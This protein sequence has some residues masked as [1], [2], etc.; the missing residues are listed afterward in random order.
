MLDVNMLIKKIDQLP[1]IPAVIKRLVDLTADPDA[2]I[3]DILELIERDQSLTASIIK[4]C[5]SSYYG[6]SKKVSSI[7]EAVV[8]VGFNTISNM[9]IT[10]GPSIY[11][12]KKVLVYDGEDVD[13]WRHS[14]LAGSCCEQLAFFARQEMI[15]V[16]YT[17][18][19]LHDIGKLVLAECDR[20]LLQK[21]VDQVAEGLSHVDAEEKVLGMHHGMIGSRLLRKWKFPGS[22]TDAVKYHHIPKKTGKNKDLT[23][24]TY[25]GNLIA[26]LAD[27][28]RR[29]PTIEDVARDRVSRR[30][31]LDEPQ[32][33]FIIQKARKQVEETEASLNTAAATTV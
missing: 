32:I 11:L 26:K 10:L 17:A 28:Q 23:E 30:F 21:V 29:G 27:D 8:M 18:G 19:L 16:A 24:I 2:D 31:Q 1:T 7:N 3:R 9:C 12:K 22:L 14:I 15:E 5:N 25:L 6:L 4:L 13:L 20:G 33:R